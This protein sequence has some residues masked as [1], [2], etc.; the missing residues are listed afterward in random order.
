MAETDAGGAV[1]EVIESNNSAVSATPVDI[2]PAYTTTLFIVPETV[3]SGTAIPITGTATLRSGGAAAF[4][5]VNIHVLNAGIERVVAALTNANGQYSTTYAPAAGLGGLFQFGASHPGVPTAPVQD[6][7]TVYA[8]VAVPSSLNIEMLESGSQTGSVTITNLSGLPV[9]GL[10]TVVAGVPNGVQFIP[11]LTGATLSGNGAA[12]LNYSI[13]STAPLSGASFT[14][15]LHTNEGASI[16][17]PVNLIVV[18]RRALITTEPAQLS[19]AMVPG[20]QATLALKIKNGGSLRTTNLR[21]L[22]PAA[23]PWLT[24]NSGQSIAPIDPGAETTVSLILQPPADL[25]LTTYFGNLVVVDDEG[26]GA[27]VPYSFR[28]VSNAR[29]GLNVDVVDEFYF[30]SAS[31]PKVV[32]A[33]VIVSDIVTG[34]VVGQGQ[35]GSGGRAS[36][37]DLRQDYYRVDVSAPGHIIMVRQ[38]RYAVNRWLWELPAGSVDAGEQPEAAA[39]RECHEEIGQIPETIVRLGALH[40]T[41]GYCDEEM[42]F[43]RLSGLETTD[44]KAA[45]DEDEDIET[46]IF[47]VR[48]ARDMVRRGEIRDM[49][50][51]AGL[52]LI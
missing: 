3:A 25:P 43:F 17:V 20:Q 36:F 5:L 7:V 34:Q 23:A 31:A 30:F 14:V 4:A 48:D 29:G 21:I 49:K 11:T 16:V 50:T 24:S 40:P 47:D 39:R 22:F 37:P 26:Q 18:A 46:R 1:S 10:R 6:Q 13:V 51:L 38:Y 32:G 27:S 2:A 15:A 8:L 12:T 45:L 33:T 42:V 9:N 44:E 41:P 35:T 52:S 28:A 19:A